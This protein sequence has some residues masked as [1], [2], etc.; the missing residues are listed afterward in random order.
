MDRGDRHP[1][2]LRGSDDRSLVPDVHVC[3]ECGSGLVH[4]VDWA[5]AGAGHWRVALRCPECEWR[6]VGFYEQA[7]LDRFDQ[8]LDAGA[9]SLRADLRRLERMNM[10]E[11]LRR[12]GALLGGDL[13]LPEDF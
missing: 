4:P 1:Q 5:T 9:D 12:F 6:T 2:P 10:E 8:I 3:P 13:V 7:V 11:E